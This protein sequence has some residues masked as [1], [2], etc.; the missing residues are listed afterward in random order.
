MR[1]VITRTVRDLALFTQALGGPAIQARS[2]SSRITIQRIALSTT[3]PLGLPVD[4]AL[5][6]AI[7]DAG[8][9]AEAAGLQV[10]RAAPPLGDEALLLDLGRRQDAAAAALARAAGLRH[11]PGALEPLLEARLARA[12]PP[13]PGEAARLRAFRARFARFFG[14]FDLLLQ[15][16]TATETPALGAHS[17]EG[18]D[19]DAHLLGSFAF[20][21][22]TWMAN[23]AGLPSMSLPLPGGG[24]PRG[25]L[26]TGPWGSEAAL[27]RFAAWWEAE[28]PWPTL[29]PPPQPSALAA[30]WK[31]PMAS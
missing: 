22:F 28:A 5:V 27:L 14:A 20:A 18:H 17:L 4:P 6:A 3:A 16:V 12:R 30:A 26:V 1:H 23:A 15:P 31:R 10:R 9:R 7:E 11:E 24:P 21:P 19:L 2:Q 8:R 13:M 29:A 25:L